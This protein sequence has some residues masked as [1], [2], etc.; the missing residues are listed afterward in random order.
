MPPAW[1]AWLLPVPMAT[2]A[3]VG[4]NS[5]RARARGPVAVI[6]SVEAYERF[7]QA[8]TAPVP[9]PRAEAWRDTGT[10]SAG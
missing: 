4:W 9:A 5:W 10:R 8:L 1:L 7:R 6:D 3:A 2:L